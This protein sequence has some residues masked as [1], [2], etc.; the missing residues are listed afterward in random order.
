[1]KNDEPLRVSVLTPSGAGAIAVIRLCGACAVSQ[2]MRCF[3]PF[4]PNAS[5]DATQ[6]GR[7]VYGR[8]FDGGD[9]VDDVLACI[10]PEASSA[11]EISC[12]GGPRV[13]ERIVE[14]LVR[15]GATRVETEAVDPTWPPA[16]AVE[17]DVLEW[18]PRAKTQRGVRYLLGQRARLSAAIRAAMAAMRDDPAEGR[19]LLERLI[20]G[21][22]A[23]RRLIEGATVAIIGPVNAGKSTLF[24]ALVGREAAITSPHPG[25][26]RD[27]VEAEIEFEGAPLTLWD[28]AGFRE[29]ADELER[30]A[31]LAA[32]ERIRRADLVLTV[33]DATQADSSGHPA[34]LEPLAENRPRVR[35]FNKLDLAAAMS[36]PFRAPQ[37]NVSHAV[38]VSARSGEGIDA[39][40]RTMLEAL[41]LARMD[42]EAPCLFSP[43]MRELVL[44]LLAPAFPSGDSNTVSDPA[45]SAGDSR[46]L[47]VAAQS[48]NRDLLDRIE[49][50]M[51]SGEHATERTA[52]L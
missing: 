36:L 23:A 26:T 6:L 38:G 29:G 3:Q 22:D 40:L 15:L 47:T 41:G 17:R 12:H 4:S 50:E 14:S 13:V 45:G 49:S 2:A 30:R 16:D 21:H 20:A 18:L 7:L 11:V 24:N 33:V 51:F 19:R 1:M 25:T 52:A 34:E 10:P 46:S 43:R 39:M 28:T 48:C 8:W 31:M 44:P 5:L 27:W 35:V 37:G 42:D 32:R 9:V